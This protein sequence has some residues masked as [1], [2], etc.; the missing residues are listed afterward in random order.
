[1]IARQ[2]IWE[3]QFEKNFFLWVVF[4]IGQWNQF[5]VG[6]LQL[7][8]DGN[9][10]YLQNMNSRAKKTASVKTRT[11]AI[12][13]CT[14]TLSNMVIYMIHG[15]IPEKFFHFLFWVD[16]EMTLRHSIGNGKFNTKY[17]L[18]LGNTCVNELS[19]GGE[20]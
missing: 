19:T 6:L 5:A 16:I 14:L 11:T 1:M 9:C 3:N 15:S 17:P 8:S 7:L 13:K 20:N 4:L 2:Y 12:K 18:K 10:H